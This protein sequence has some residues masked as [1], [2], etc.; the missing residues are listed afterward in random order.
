MSCASCVRHI[1]DALS[2]VDGVVSVRVNFAASSASILYDDTKLKVSDIKKILKDIGYPAQE[3]EGAITTLSLFVKVIVCLLIAVT[4]FVVDVSRMFG[5]EIMAGLYQFILATIVQVYGGYS[6]YV[7]SYKSIM[8]K[9]LGMDVLV[10]LGTTTAYLFSTIAWLTGYQAKL[11]FETSSVVIA[12]VL[13]G[14]LLEA[15]AKKRARKSMKSLLNMQPKTAR[16]VIDGK[17]EIVSIDDIVPGDIIAVGTF[18]TIPVDGK[19][20]Q[21][22]STADES[23]ITGE[24]DGVYKDKGDKVIGGTINQDGA[25]LVECHGVGVDSILGRMIQVVEKAQMTRPKIQRLVDQVA[26]I[27]I[28]LVLGIALATLVITWVYVS[29]EEAIVNMVATLVIACPCALGLATP[30]VTMVSGARAARAGILVKDFDALEVAGKL[31]TLVFDKTG[32]VTEG[33]MK[34]VQ[35]PRDERVIKIAKSLAKHSSHPLAKSLG[36]E[37]MDVRG[38]REEFGRGV[39]GKI[40]DKKV[41]LG[42]ES[43]LRDMG[44][45]IDQV[46]PENTVVMIGEEDK[47]IGIYAFEDK[48][49]DDAHLAIETIKKQGIETILLSGDKKKVVEH[50]GKELGFHEY[51]GEVSP[52]GKGEFVKKLKRPIAMIGDGVNDALAFNVADVAIAMGSGTDVAFESASIGIMQN[53]VTSISKLIFLG[54]ATRNRIK[55]NLFLAFGYN[56]IALPLAAFGLVNP[57]VG[58]LA[59]SASSILVVTNAFRRY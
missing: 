34:M 53:R 8:K 41:Y 18:E 48:I 46:I 1:K 20:L 33:R 54:R 35:S 4:L 57:M 55:Q 38:V 49:R 6:F 24:S 19:I 32:T 2:S 58:A 59:M 36:S 40:N 37:E 15:R 13:V 39:F 7:Q 14:K 52:E 9:S 25:I 23:M 56:I 16:R 17:D 5:H 47:L 22:S 45:K 44:V 42:S 21:G 10:A 30:T 43:F 27:F 29:F 12:L 28:P 11:Y 26:S 31:R 3:A 51:H 50:V